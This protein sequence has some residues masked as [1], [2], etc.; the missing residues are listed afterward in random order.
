MPKSGQWIDEG[1]ARVSY[2]GPIPKDSTRPET[3]AGPSRSEPINGTRSGRSGPT[4]GAGPRLPKLQTVERARG[5]LLGLD[6]VGVDHSRVDV[7]VTEQG[8]DR[9]QVSPALQEV[10]GEAVAQG[11]YA[12][13]FRD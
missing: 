1:S 3:D 13:V 11:M 6:D 10:R 9:P 8:L 4:G 2:T 7:L 5:V 12:G